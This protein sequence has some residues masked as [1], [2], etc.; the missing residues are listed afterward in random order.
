M[1]IARRA[2]TESFQ[3]VPWAKL[4]MVPIPF[5]PWALVIVRRKFFK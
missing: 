5:T 3:H 2:D 4:V 1:S